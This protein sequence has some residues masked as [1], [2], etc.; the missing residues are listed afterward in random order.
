V[1]VRFGE[2]FGRVLIAACHAAAIA[3][4]VAAWVAWRMPAGA[5]AASAAAAAFVPVSVAVLRGRDGAAL[6]GTLAA[7]GAMLYAYGMAFAAGIVLSPDAG[8]PT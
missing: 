2:R 5:M 6:N 7:F 8:A 1:I 4:P 3:V